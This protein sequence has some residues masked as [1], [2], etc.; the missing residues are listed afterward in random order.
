MND[1]QNIEV[2][3]ATLIAIRLRAREVAA[4]AKVEVTS[5]Q[6]AL[7]ALLSRDKGFRK[8][9]AAAVGAY[10]EQEEK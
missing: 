2:D 10:G 5:D 6:D 3:G 8:H 9:H 4:K 7:L 1:K